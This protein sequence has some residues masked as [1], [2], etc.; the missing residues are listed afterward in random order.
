[1]ASFFRTSWHFE[2]YPLRVR[3]QDLSTY[4]GPERMRP[5]AWQAQFPRWIG[6]QGSGKTGE[7][8]VANLRSNFD[9]YV[10]SGQRLPRPGTYKSLDL[11]FGSRE[12]ISFF[13]E[14]ED[15][16]IG[17]ILGLPWAFLSDESSL[18]EINGHED[19]EALYAKIT[20]KYGV[21]VSDV[22]DANIAAILAKID[23]ERKRS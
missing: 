20:A 17:D 18:W 14:L 13:P 8:A 23:A 2:D 4:A 1:M 19:N 10:T 21:D 11:D 22:A 7:Q 15:E 9:A 12:K 3:E 5:C 6:L 16:F